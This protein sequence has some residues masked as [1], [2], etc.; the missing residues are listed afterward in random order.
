LE[1][2][3]AEYHVALAGVLGAA[4]GTRELERAAVL[5]PRD[6]E[7]LV[8]LGVRAEMRGDVGEAERRLLQA[9]GVDRTYGPSWALANFYFR[10]GDG[11][12]FRTWARRAAEMAYGDA[13]PLFRL[14]WEAGGDAAASIPRRPEVERQYLYFLLTTDRLDA[15]GPMAARLRAR[16]TAEDEAALMAYCERLIA[17]G[18]AA[19]AVPVWNGIRRDE[20][21]GAGLVNGGFEKTPSS[22]GFDWRLAE[23]AGVSA[24]VDAGALRIEYT[25]EEPE[26]C[27]ALSQYLALKAGGRYR[28][29]W[30]YRTHG[31]EPA[32]GLKWR[33]ADGGGAIAESGDLA[34]GEWTQGEFE[35]Q[36]RTTAG[37]P[38]LALVYE[39]ATGTVRIQGEIWVRK[40]TLEELP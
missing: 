36:A 35:F 10:R 12:R 13:T 27:E 26:R 32:T 3:R 22:R 19:E 31:I 39:R 1:P 15:A 18:R 20:R 38:R 14:L 34:S 16:G 8:E 24:A 2:G 40:V 37:A 7:T 5:N 17:A 30:E 25:G 29:R 28:M 21:A 6:S 11:E 23:I 9:A 4:A 33:V